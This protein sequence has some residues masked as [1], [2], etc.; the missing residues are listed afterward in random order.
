[1]SLPVQLDL[2]ATEDQNIQ[3]A[4]EPV[5]LTKGLRNL[6]LISGAGGAEVRSAINAN[7]TAGAGEVRINAQTIT[8]ANAAAGRLCIRA[9]HIGAVDAGTSNGTQALI[10]NEI[11]SLSLGNAPIHIYFAKV[12]TLVGKSAGAIGAAGQ[13]CLH[14][15]ATIENFD[16]YNPNV[17]DSTC[18]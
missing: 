2:K 1:M 12:K 16:G 14:N 4:A 5:I 17:A 6:T 13:I 15:G 11:D 3:G 8:N 9:D 10:A 7:L 18:L